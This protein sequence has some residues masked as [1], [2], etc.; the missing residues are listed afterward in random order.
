M[1]QIVWLTVILPVGIS[2][3]ILA[4]MANGLLADPEVRVEIDEGLV[5]VIIGAL[6]SGMIV[7]NILVQEWRT[8]MEAQN[9]M[10]A[11]AETAAEHRRFLNR[12]DHELK[13]PLMAIR[14]GL[15][16]LSG[17]TDPADRADILASVETQAQRLGHLIGDLRKVA[18]IGAKPLEPS[19]IDVKD[20]LEEIY[21][22]ARDEPQAADRH[23]ALSLPQPPA[24]LPGIRG[25]RDL[26]LL[27]LHNV[28]NN[29]MKFSRPGDRVQISGYTAGGVVLI[30]VRDTGPGIPEADLAHV[31]EELYRGHNA[32]GIAGSGIGL[33]LVQSIVARHQGRVTLQS[34]PGQ[35]TAVTLQL[36][37]AAAEPV[38]LRAAS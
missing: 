7:L 34:T 11:R 8:Y 16:N 22:I 20:L 24:A 32:Q 29:A 10:R 12:L 26:L 9:M 18:E 38:P 23:L 19:A 37:I 31:W 15:A 25:D 6:L 13:N 36:P 14:A 1:K 30:E 27:A 21:D 4:L 33:S 5:V 2:L 28:V 17:A 35:G 3:V